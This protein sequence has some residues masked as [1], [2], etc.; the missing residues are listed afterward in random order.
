MNAVIA[1]IAAAQLHSALAQ[2]QTTPVITLERTACFGVCPVYTVTIQDDGT[3]Q[4]QGV[5]H[6]RVAGVHMWKI[7]PLAV[8]ALAR[9]MQ[10]A[11]FFEM[12]DAYRMPVTDMPTT[13]TTLT[14]GGRTKRITDYMGAPQALAE[15][16]A[17]IDEVSGAKGYVRVSAPVIRDRQKGG[18]RATDDEARA[19]MLEAARNGDAGVVKALIDAGASAR[20]ADGDGVTL[21]MR[22]AMSGDPETVRVLLAG[23]GDPTARDKWG[24]NAA[25]RARD[26]LHD[27]TIAPVPVEATGRPRDYALVLKLLTDE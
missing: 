7:E 20:A 9:G 23:G 15:I 13:Y 14:I 10:K 17:R 1:L 4:Y 19:W 8:D 22:A 27:S 16:E 11:G 25:D 12:K 24:R 6:V 2:A 5:Q 3:V 26:G 18:W 21:V